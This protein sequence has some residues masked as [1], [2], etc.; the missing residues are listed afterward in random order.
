[1][2][3]CD[4]TGPNTVLRAGRYVLVGPDPLL[5][6]CRA[7]ANAAA[8][9]VIG[10]AIP[11][12]P[13]FREPAFAEFQKGCCLIGREQRIGL[14]SLRC[15]RHRCVRRL[16]EVGQTMTEV[17]PQIV[18]SFPQNSNTAKGSGSRLSANS[19]ESSILCLGINLIEHARNCIFARNL[20]PFLCPFHQPR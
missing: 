14:S 12:Q 18:G 13:C 17:F 4:F 1:M 3:Y 5:Q 6:T 20:R 16:E 9:L 15:R 2:D 8:Q 19:L 7:I 11:V 10:R